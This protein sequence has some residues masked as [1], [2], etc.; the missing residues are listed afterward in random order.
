MKFFILL[1]FL[2][3]SANAY[4][5][6]YNREYAQKEMRK[7]SHLLSDGKGTYKG[8][9]NI[10]ATYYKLFIQINLNPNSINAYTQINAT[11]LKNSLSQV[12]LD[13]T[14]GLTV[15]SVIQNNNKV[16]WTHNSN[17][18]FIDLK[19]SVSIGE[20]ISVTV[21]Y[22]GLPPLDNESFVFSTQS[23]APLI[24][25]LSEPFGASDWFVCKNTPSDKADSSDVWVKCSSELIAGSNGLLVETLNNGDGTNTYKW[26]N[27]YPI[28][29]YLISLAVT[30]YTKYDIYFRYSSGDSLPIVNYIYPSN[31]NSVK[32]NIDKTPLMLGFYTNVFGEYPFINEKYGHAQITWG[33]AMEHQTMSSMGTFIESVIAH[34]LVHQ[35]FGDKITCEDW[36]E[37]WLNEGFA[38]YGAALWGEHSYGK[39]YYRNDI[40]QIMID[41][42]RAVGSIY[43]QEP[44]SVAEIFNGDRSYAK[45]CI[46]LHMLR[47]V[48]GDS[49]FFKTIKTYAN[50]SLLA[51]KSA[52]TSDFKNVAEMVSGTNLDYFFNQWIYGEGYPKYDLSWSIEQTENT[53]RTN[54][55]IN[56]IQEITNPLFFT[57]PV[58]I[59]FQFDNGD[60]TVKVFNNQKNQVFTFNFNQKPRSYKFDPDNLIL[61]DINTE[62]PVIPVSYKLYQN[63]PNPFN[64]ST[65]I[66][67]ELKQP[68]RV[69]LSLFDVTGRIVG[70]LLNEN[71]REGFHTTEFFIG[72]LP[73]GIY[74]YNIEVFDDFGLLTFS[75]SRKMA[76]IK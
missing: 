30:N 55:N 67:F 19:N 32:P 46:V 54:F 40:S 76:F 15:D 68:G 75:D 39:E 35:W 52:T 28:A 50:D 51:Y 26:S 8:D 24:W 9:T 37:I 17:K 10:D 53:Y 69:K 27:R 34:E 49:L 63:Y 42:R 60:T 48:L 45:G 18:I 1:C 23:G 64:P 5:Q 12:F 74:Y 44:N 72:N 14:N 33:G 62:P 7:Y 71:R 58:E 11:S 3:I 47:G 36:R 25:T 21:Y 66:D 65:R 29:Q 56:Q 38:T 20:N 13:L 22:H 43:V 31:F 57:M 6:S 41:A 2:F 4:T 73:T 16:S 59:F 70:I 61:K